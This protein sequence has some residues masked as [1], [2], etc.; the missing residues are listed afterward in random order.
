MFLQL[1]REEERHPG[2][3]TT[4]PRFCAAIFSSFFL[5]MLPIPSFFP[6]LE[7]NKGPAQQIFL[8]EECVFIHTVVFSR[9][10]ILSLLSL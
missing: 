2:P 1:Y 3:S 7:H 10:C 6:S 5:K 8:D 4:S 9:A